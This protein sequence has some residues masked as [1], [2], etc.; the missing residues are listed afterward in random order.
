MMFARSIAPNFIDGKLYLEKST[1]LRSRSTKNSRLNDGRTPR[2]LLP[3]DVVAQLCRADDERQL[4]V[5][6]VVQNI[7]EEFC[8][9]ALAIMVHRLKL[10]ADS[11]QVAQLRIYLAV[12]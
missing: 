5:P 7:E 3:A 6:A 11:A 1:V 8:G 12:L 10:L 4:P 9:E 2:R